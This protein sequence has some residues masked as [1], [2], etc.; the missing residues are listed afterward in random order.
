MIY[1]VRL[2]LTHIYD[3]PAAHGRSLIRVVP[4]SI[5][6]RQRLT[7]H[8][9]DVTPVPH[10]RSEGTD[11]FGNSVLTSS[12]TEPHSQLQIALA[13]HV[14]MTPGLPPS[15][16]S[17]SISA[18]REDWQRERDL[19]PS[20]P[21]HFLGPTARLKPDPDISAFAAAVIS[22]TATV[23]ENVIRLG[24]ALH[25]AMTFDSAATTVDTDASE[26]FRM[27][28]GVCQDFAHIMILG[29]QS[30]GIP[31]GYV[32]GYLRTL[33][34][35]GGEKLEGVDAMHA[36]VKAWCGVA[37]GWVEYDPTNKTLIGADHIVVG[38]GREYNDVAPI[39]GRLRS[40]GGQSSAQAVDVA[41]VSGSQPTE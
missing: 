37:Q 21:L 4:T 12:H 16:L 32:S 5:P 25:A 30:L 13:C 33:P 10:D 29:L 23:T 15:D 2:T 6:G 31:A 36:W 17:P 22:K 39:R 40:A 24:E 1:N 35:E 34:P 28:R 8:V 14:A 18:L 38:Y 41:V 9:L 20:S 3:Q 19:G 11:F 26:A 27:R 7:A